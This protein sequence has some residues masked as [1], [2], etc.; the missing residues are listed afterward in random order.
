[1][2]L[3][4]I[5]FGKDRSFWKLLPYTILFFVFVIKLVSLNLSLDLY[6]AGDSVSYILTLQE[7]VADGEITFIISQPILFNLLNILSLR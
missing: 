7:I 5:K 4:K 6:V 1:M 2:D 3:I